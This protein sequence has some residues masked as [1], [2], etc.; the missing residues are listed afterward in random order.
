MTKEQRYRKAH[1]EF[2]KKMADWN[3]SFGEA[4]INNHRRQRAQVIIG[5]MR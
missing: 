4:W 3:K 5:M 2:C 1:G